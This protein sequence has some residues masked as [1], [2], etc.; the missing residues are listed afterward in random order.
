MT[1]RHFSDNGYQIIDAS[2]KSKVLP[3][4]QVLRLTLD[5]RRA[6][7]LE[8]DQAVATLVDGQVLVGQ[9]TGAA[10]D[11]ESLLFQLSFAE[12]EVELSIDDLLSISLHPKGRSLA[13]ED[14]DV[15][16]LATGEMLVGFVDAIDDRSVAFV[17]GDADEPITIPME[18]VHGLAIANK[19]KPTRPEVGKEVT[20]VHLTDGSVYLIEHVGLSV[21]AKQPI[22]IVTGKSMLPMVP[23]AVSVPMSRVSRLE[24]LS[25]K[26]SLRPLASA[27]WSLFAGGEVF[28]VPMPPYVLPNGVFRLHAPMTLMFEPPRG[29]RRLV[30]NA[31]LALDGDLPQ[32]RRA[33]AGCE[34]V[35]HEGDK[36]LGQFSLTP[37]NAMTRINLPLAAEGGALRLELRPGINGPVLDRVRLTD[38]ELLMVGP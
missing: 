24:P 3:I 16:L 15:L 35:I 9:L 6:V 20:R 27:P 5:G 4:D 7:A 12:R 28:G 22:K 33:L 18:R 31:T 37:D 34:L 2:G 8:E 26:Q 1:L 38:A 13:A 30:M 21:H 32:A 10:A 36:L 25:G 14:D 23:A 11:R 19:P 29:A 17:V